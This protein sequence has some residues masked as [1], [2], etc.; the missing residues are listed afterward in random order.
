MSCVSAFDE[1]VI[2]IEPVIKGTI[3]SFIKMNR[4]DE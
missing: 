4:R 3:V 2:M 1:M